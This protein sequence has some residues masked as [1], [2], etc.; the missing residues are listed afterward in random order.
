MKLSALLQGI[1]HEKKNFAEKEIASLCTDSR[2]SGANDLFFCFRGT[3]VD[4]HRFAK[5]AARR[6]VSAIVCEHDCGVACPQIL[7]ADGREGMA[8]IA[9]NFYQN[10]QNS[11][12][13]IGITGTNGKTTTAHMLYS[14]LKE[15]GKKAGLIGTLGAKYG[16]ITVPPDLTTPDPVCLFSLLSD[17]LCHGVEYVVMEVSA[18]ALAL[19]KVCPI[20]FETAIFTNLTH[21][22]LDFFHDMDSYGGAKRR[23]FSEENSRFCVLNADEPFT[24]TVKRERIVTYG[25]ENPADSFA[26]V[27]KEDARGSKILLNISDELCE[28]TL[29]MGGRHNVYNALAA[30][31]AAL[32]LGISTEQIGRGLSDCGQVDGRLEFVASYRG[33]DIF[34]DF[35]HTPDGLEKSLAALKRHCKGKLFCLFGCGGN[36]DEKKRPIMGETVAKGCDFAILSSDNPRYE[37]PCSILY[38]IEKGYQR[39]SRNYISVQER[40]KA[41][42]YA[43]NLL[44]EGDILLVAGKGGETYQEIMGVKYSYND[45]EVIKQLIAGERA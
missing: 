35:A 13:I 15:A 27:Q 20:F 31:T 26:V 42:A 29:S 2:I 8:R 1:A 22:H 34:V 17:M 36:R 40:E 10:P 12:K 19:K 7:L 28:C 25:L 18:H 44:E 39:V 32:H 23:L 38:E 6:G 9:A 11:L 21:D 3:R 43:L 24:R 16:E 45:K 33:A 14:I 30:A 37:D 5:E 4:S 41:T